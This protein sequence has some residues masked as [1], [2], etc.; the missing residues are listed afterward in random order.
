MNDDSALHNVRTAAEVATFISTGIL[1]TVQQ[2]LGTALTE[3]AGADPDLVAEETLSMVSVLTARQVAGV[4]EGHSP[5]EA[6]LVPVLREIPN[7]YYDYL[8]GTSVVHHGEAAA[9]TDRAYD[10][11]DRKRQFYERQAEGGVGSVQG[12]TSVLRD[13]LLRISPPSAP[14]VPSLDVEAAGVEAALE[15]HLM[16]VEAYTRRA[17]TSR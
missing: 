10:R 3:I 4:L 15:V 16:L 9:G 1:T 7:T 12:I 13:W 5:L 8:V 17:I 6:A 2:I 14:G 11:L